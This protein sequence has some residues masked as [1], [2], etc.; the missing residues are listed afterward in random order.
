MNFLSLAQRV[1]QLC[2]IQGSGPS[3]VSG[4]TGILSVVV[5]ETAQAYVEIQTLSDRWNFR[6]SR[7]EFTT[8]EDYRD[9]ELAGTDID[10]VAEDSISCYVEGSEADEW[11]LVFLP[12]LE[13]RRRF[14]VG[15]HES[16][17][18]QF[19]TLLP[20]NAFRLHPAPDLSTYKV[21]GDYY[22]KVDTLDANT[23]TPLL[24]EK[25]HMAIAYKAMIGVGS[26]QGAQDVVQRGERNFYLMLKDMYR[27]ELP[28]I[29]FRMNPIA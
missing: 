14:G 23:D 7:F 25:Y 12:H 26:Y 9:Y 1:R 24:P 22:R 20:S 19:V 15:T 11:P 8:T 13:F 16:S 18:P 21:R 2:G 3:S 4:Q 28:D 29:V 10:H 27:D 5:N 17:V 6:W